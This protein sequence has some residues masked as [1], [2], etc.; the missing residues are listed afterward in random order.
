MSGKCQ[1]TSHACNSPQ[2]VGA[3]PQ[4]GNAAQVLQG[5]FLLLQWVSILVAIS[6]EIDCC[7]FELNLRINVMFQT[8]FYKRDSSKASAISA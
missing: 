2:C 1:G 3:R 8:L 5:V 7:G 4:V 6:N